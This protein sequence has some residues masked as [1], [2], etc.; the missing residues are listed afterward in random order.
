MRIALVSSDPGTSYGGTEVLIDSLAKRLRDLDIET[1]LVFHPANLS[2]VEEIISTI[3]LVQKIDLTGHDAVITFRFPSYFVEHP[4]K[5]I[6]LLHQ[7]RPLM[8]NYGT[9]FGF[10][11]TFSHDLFKQQL[12]RLDQ[13]VFREAGTKLRVNSAITRARTVESVGINPSILMCPLTH[14]FDELTSIKR[15]PEVGF[16]NFIFAGGRIS[17]DKR[18]HL[19][20]L[21]AIESRTNLV[22]AG[23]PDN[24]DYTNELKRNADSKNVLIIPRRLSYSELAWLYSHSNAVFYGPKNEDSYGYVAGEASYF[25]AELITCLDSGDVATFGRFMKSGVAE[26][27]YIDI[28]SYFTRFTIQPSEIRKNEIRHDWN[29][30]STDWRDVE[31][32]VLQNLS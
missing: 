9:E 19:A 24:S 8:D 4:N 14:Q 18:Q 29:N 13:K 26:P 11:K 30:F 2:N 31:K 15:P 21:A 1:D 10:H 28:A 3:S 20:V 27:N 6:W 25:G 12:E 17:P 16:D 23:S 7:F 5:L 22:V 32:W